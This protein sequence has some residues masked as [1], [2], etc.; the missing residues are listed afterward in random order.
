MSKIVVKKLWQFVSFAA[1]LS[2]C[3]D[4]RAQVADTTVKL[5]KNSIAEVIAAMTL[6]EKTELVVGA[7]ELK[8]ASAGENGTT[9]GFTAQKVPGAAGIM[10][11]IPRLGIPALILSDGPAGVRINP[12]RK[13]DGQTYYATAFPSGTSLAS[14]WDT[15]LVQMVGTAF[16]NEVKEYGID[17]I[18]APGMNI[19]RNPLNGRNFEYYSEDPLLSGK[20]AAAIVRGIQSNGVG[21]SV[22]HFAA[23][24]Q[25]ANRNGVNVIMSERNLRE[26]YL[27]GFRTAIT[28]SNPWTVMSSYNKINDTFTAE[29]HG[30]LTTILRDEWNYN[31]FV[32]TDWGGGRN[33]PAIIAAGNDLIMPGRPGQ[34]AWIQSA[35]EHDSLSM[36]TLDKSVERILKII[37]QSPAFQQYSFS[38]KPDLAAHAALVRTAGAEGMVLL[39][40]ESGTLPLH[41]AMKVAV[42]GNTSFK[43]IAGGMGSGDVNKAYVISVIK[44][45]ELAGFHPNAELVKTYL[46]YFSQNSAQ[47]V[48]AGAKWP[49]A[50][51]E[52]ILPNSIIAEMAATTDIALLTIGRNSA[53]TLDRNLE[54]NYTLTKEEQEQI[55]RIA[56]AFHTQHKRLVIIL[57]IAGVIDMKQW[58]DAADAIL[59]A[60]QPGQEAGHSVA[61]VLLGKVN[62]S[63]KL[64][65]TFPVSYKDVSSAKNFPGTPVEK[66]LQVNY[67]EGIYVGYRYH[68]RFNVKPFYEFGYGLSYTR[69]SI[70]NFSLQKL[71]ADGS[72]SVRFKVMNTG[73]IPGKQVVQLYVS[74][75][76]NTIDK[77]EQELRAFAKTRLLQP[78]KSQQITLFVKGKDLA[79]FHT[80]R[81]AWITDTGN[82]EV[83]LGFSS[84][85][86]LQK[87]I[88]NLATPIKVE[89]VHSV[90]PL[91]T[92]LQ[93]FKSS[94]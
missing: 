67:E 86:I 41:E 43:T 2:I 28:E 74:A 66:S 51:P 36:A 21:T 25:E 57:N 78:K 47:Q 9:I 17:I 65:T 89:K 80:N 94:N 81:S 62:P 49:K 18:F 59:L 44:G 27:R 11:V 68:D 52:L 84:R 32:M 56:M 88:F 70:T 7:T 8:K 85:N 35:V 20:T 92:P 13:N 22:K 55:R 93:E 77:P 63:S 42:F 10:A 46:Q 3:I 14:T 39:K 82:Y 4:V 79:S 30:L 40:N 50:A 37:L 1:L 5:G 53:E 15:A 76:K 38:N 48:A 26:L 12:H 24:N 90:L 45:I 34:S 61:D 33:R 72:F 75:P 58:S 71:Q 16:G 29:S 60:W 23:N 91:H 83:R 73:K 19:H 64:A 54:N 69:F 6:Q 87:A 31:G